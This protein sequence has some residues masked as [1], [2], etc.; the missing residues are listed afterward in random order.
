MALLD[1][2]SLRLSPRLCDRDVEAK[3]E[4]AKRLGPATALGAAVAPAACMAGSL[5]QFVAR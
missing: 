4:Q 3:E 5:Q 1:P 2:Y